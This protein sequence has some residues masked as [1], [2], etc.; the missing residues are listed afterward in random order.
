MSQTEVSQ[1]G[2]ADRLREARQLLLRGAYTAAEG[3]LFTLLQKPEL[4][5]D[6]NLAAQL[7]L[8]LLYLAGAQSTNGKTLL[9][10]IVSSSDSGVLAGLEPKIHAAALLIKSNACFILAEVLADQG[11]YGLARSYV[12]EAQKYIVTYEQ[13][14]NGDSSSSFE[15][16]LFSCMDCWL[17]LKDWQPEL[18]TKGFQLAALG[19]RIR[20]LAEFENATR[21]Q[22][23]KRHLMVGEYLFMVAQFLCAKSNDP[24]QPGHRIRADNVQEKED[25][26]KALFDEGR[27]LSG[28]AQISEFSLH[29][30][31]PIS[32]KITSFSQHLLCDSA[33]CFG[34][35]YQA[36]QT[37]QT[38]NTS[39]ASIGHPVRGVIIARLKEVYK[40]LNDDIQIDYWNKQLSALRK[41]LNS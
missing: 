22:T 11:K 40:A 35:A 23:W 15:S 19:G 33:S 17:Q 6:L 3:E 28:I 4:T 12:L 16:K 41:C 1:S 37:I 25:R 13:I 36:L 24:N 18:S 20:S 34:Q 2:G 38:A 32:V 9:E 5:P 27:Q 29:P 30:R 7:E 8:A 14:W 31:M 21:E 26:L 10:K 39:Q